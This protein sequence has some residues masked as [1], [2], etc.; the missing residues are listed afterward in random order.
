[1][2]YL[3]YKIFKAI[4]ERA[5]K[6]L[7]Q[8]VPP[9]SSKYQEEKGLII[10]NAARTDSDEQTNS[11]SDSSK[12]SQGVS[13]IKTLSPLIEGDETSQMYHSENDDDDEESPTAEKDDCQVISNVAVSSFVNDKSPS[14]LNDM[15]V[16]C[17][18][19][20]STDLPWV[21]PSQNSRRKSRTAS[22]L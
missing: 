14:P 13:Y 8:K 9:R 2:V 17:P 11:K 7:G 12:Q 3:Y 22:S 5:R 16:G 6:A 4:H 21:T 1:M 20:R 10:E 18:A 19:S 15:K